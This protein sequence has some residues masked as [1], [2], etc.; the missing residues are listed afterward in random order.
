MEAIESLRNQHRE[1]LSIFD[2]LEITT[3]EL[4]RTLLAQIAERLNAF[5]GRG[6]G[7]LSGRP[8]AGAGRRGDRR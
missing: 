5:R 2:E 4:E 6:R 8:H 7:L 1:M 3:D